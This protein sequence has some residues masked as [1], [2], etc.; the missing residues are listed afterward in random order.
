MYNEMKQYSVCD[1]LHNTNQTYPITKPPTT[2]VHRLLEFILGR[3]CFRFGNKTFLQKIGCV[4][5]STASPEI[6][7]ITLHDFE[8]R[9]LEKA[10]CILSWWHNMDGILVVYDGNQDQF[11]ELVIS[12]TSSI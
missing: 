10:K 12:K 3:N 8:K 4:M 5:G 11:E 7:N 1:A 9:I 6:C 2:Y